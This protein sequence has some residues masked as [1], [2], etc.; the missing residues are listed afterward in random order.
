MFKYLWQLP[1]NLIGLFFSW[2]SNNDW[3]IYYD[4]LDTTVYY[5]PDYRVFNAGVCFGQYIILARQYWYYNRKD[6]E[7]VIR[8]EC[9]HSKQSLYLGWF[10]LLLV[11][12]PSL[13]VNIWDRMFHKKWNE[14][15][16]LKWY[17]NRY[18]EKWADKLGGVER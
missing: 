16:R 3:T 8:H 5:V 7:K 10:Y 4:E 11:G 13:C 17:Y 2:F 6:L 9:G 15:K 18:P 12:L 14:E 1:Q